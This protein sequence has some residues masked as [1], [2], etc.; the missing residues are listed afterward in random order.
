VP[1]V[2][3]LRGARCVVLQSSANVTG[4]PDA[5]RI[6]EVPDAIRAGADLVVD[7]GELPGTPSTVVDLR[8]YE[9]TGAW[10]ILRAG[11]VTAR[12]IAEAARVS[13]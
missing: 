6:E 12:T 1:D 8:G 7:A 3:L 9:D 11:A 4:G 10:A 13:S 5:R 2:P